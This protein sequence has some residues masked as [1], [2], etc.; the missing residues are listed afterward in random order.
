MCATWKSIKSFANIVIIFWH[1]ALHKLL[2]FSH[3]YIFYIQFVYKAS[4]FNLAYMHM[5][6]VYIKRCDECE[7]IKHFVIIIIINTHAGGCD[8]FVARVKLK[9]ESSVAS[10]GERALT[11]H[12]ACCCTRCPWLLTG[13]FKCAAA[14]GDFSAASECCILSIMLHIYFL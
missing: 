11:Y 1:I 5:Y 14:G 2:P 7:Y 9:L 13:I 4:Q 12:L 8:A 3:I 10:D 6:N